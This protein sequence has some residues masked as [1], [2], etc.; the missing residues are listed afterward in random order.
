MTDVSDAVESGAANSESALL[1]GAQLNSETAAFSLDLNIDMAHNQSDGGLVLHAAPAA[2]AT[3]RRQ[4]DYRP[5]V[6]VEVT[7]GRQPASEGVRL[8]Q[9]ACLEAWQR[10]LESK[11]PMP[12]DQG[13]Q[14]LANEFRDMFG[15]R[16]CQPQS[17]FAV[18]DTERTLVLVWHVSLRPDSAFPAAPLALVKFTPAEHAIPQAENLQLGTAGYYRRLEEAGNGRRDEM[19]TR[20]TI[21]IR[22]AIRASGRADLATRIP[23]LSGEAT[24]TTDGQ[25]LYCTAAMPSQEADIE[26]LRQE[27]PQDSATVIAEPSSFAAELANVFAAN[28]PATRLD[29]TDKAKLAYYRTHQIDH[30]V[31]MFHGPVAYTDDSEAVFAQPPHLRGIAS[32]FVK[33][34]EYGK[35]QEYRFA[36]RTV[37]E[38]TGDVLRLPVSETLRG[39]AEPARL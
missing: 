3:Q 14:K 34:Q 26:R 12:R 6:Q 5:A 8:V 17:A 35:Q 24:Y 33:R 30:V 2:P 21:D 11:P 31:Q 36:V 4:S 23:P 22:G 37:G 7:L 9:Q 18:G 27:F 1:D 13:T 16:W 15:S 25:W 39:L 32:C 19:E 29:G 38:P 28:L 20:Q 10:E